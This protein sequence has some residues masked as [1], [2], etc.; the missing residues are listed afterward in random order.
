MISTI[1]AVAAGG[2]IGA[3]MRHGVNSLALDFYGDDF[4]W[5]TLVVNVIGCFCLGIA[6]MVFDHMWEPSETMR[7]FLIT[8]VIGAFTTFSTFSLDSIELWEKG[9]TLSAAGYMMASV[10]LSITALFAA[11]ALIRYIAA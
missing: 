6:I 3:V 11:M 9:A 1:G 5:G 8:G 10:I 7:R 4:P 2:A